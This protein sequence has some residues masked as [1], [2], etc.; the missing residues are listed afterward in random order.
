MALGTYFASGGGLGPCAP[1]SQQYSTSGHEGPISL[2]NLASGHIRFLPPSLQPHFLSGSVPA[3]DRAQGGPGWAV[4]R[5]GL[6]CGEFGG[7]M[8][9]PSGAQGSFL[10]AFRGVCEERIIGGVGD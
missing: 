6:G 1:N 7:S 9:H 10:P 5:P 8:G 2:P 3:G 4:L